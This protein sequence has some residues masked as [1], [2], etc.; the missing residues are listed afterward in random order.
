MNKKMNSRDIKM[1][2]IARHV[3]IALT[4][5]ILC[6]G[7]GVVTAI[8]QQ[9]YTLYG[10]ARLN[11]KVLTAQDDDV[12]SLEVDGV[13]LV[14]Y[15]MGDIPNTDNY[16]LKVPMDSDPGV[17]TAAQEGDTAYTYI[18]GIAINEGPQIIGAP[19]T[20]VQ[21]GISAT[22]ANNP[23]SVTVLYPNG[24]ESILIGTQVE[25]SA[26]A[27]DDAA[28]TGVTFYYSSD[29]GSNWNLI[30]AGTRVS[31]T[32]KDGIWNRTWDTNG[33]SAGTNYLI[34]AVASDGTSTG[35][36]QSDSAFSLTGTQ[37][38]LIILDISWSPENPKEG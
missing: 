6:F 26:H 25:V 34:K 12:I 37:P 7:I 19:G 17:T 29:G 3:K 22:S 1:G 16:V 27:I 31:G 21:F 9:D 20:I 24:G 15:T 10:T 4:I 36:D 23:P 13:E 18:N 8:P 2:R 38:D 14:S 30:G 11:G 28:V 35:E 32:A 33:L 5:A